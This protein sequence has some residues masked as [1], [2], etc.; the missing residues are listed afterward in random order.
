MTGRW[1]SRDPI[2][3][4]GGVN[5]YAFVGNDGA[6]RWDY[7]GL[8]KGYE[9]H[10]WFPVIRRGGKKV[11]QNAVDAVCGVGFLDINHYVTTL[12]GKSTSRNTSHYHVTHTLKY[13][14]AWNSMYNGII[15]S[16]KRED[17]CCVLLIAT[18]LAVDG[19]MHWLHQEKLKGA[20]AFVGPVE[21]AT[22]PRLHP[23]RA[24][25]P[26]TT[27]D[28]QA[29]ITKACNKCNKKREDFIRIAQKHFNALKNAIDSVTIP[30]VPV[31]GG[32]TP[33]KPKPNLGPVPPFSPPT[34]P[35]P[36]L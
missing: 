18:S 22:R 9:D 34:A 2:E 24:M 4:R 36:S 11:G 32:V 23:Y 1:P 21:H 6:D 13:T 28:L 30:P 31:P 19:T 10:H 20:P 7:L 3:E 25:G 12:G 27:P 5:L 17:R 15:A 14:Q 8:I 29:R 33:P 16:V 35:V 26:D